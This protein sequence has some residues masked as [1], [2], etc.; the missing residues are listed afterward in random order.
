MAHNTW[1]RTGAERRAD[2]CQE[3]REA[4]LLGQRVCN[5]HTELG[6]SQ[7][8]PAERTGMTKPQVSRLET[9][10]VAPSPAPLRRLAKALDADLKPL[11]RPPGATPGDIGDTSRERPKLGP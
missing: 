2:A 7:A 11:T 6:L 1:E 5:R 8:E 9:G 4:L 10:G 3:A